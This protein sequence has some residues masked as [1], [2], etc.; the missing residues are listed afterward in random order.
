[1]LDVIELL[2][3]ELLEFRIWISVQVSVISHLYITPRMQITRGDVFCDSMLFMFSSDI[4]KRYE[5]VGLSF[6]KVVLVLYSFLG[7]IILFFEG[8]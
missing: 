6:E 2:S 7:I 4:V 5:D 1:M 3:F 8:W